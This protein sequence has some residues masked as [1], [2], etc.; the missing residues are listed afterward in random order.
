MRGKLWSEFHKVALCELPAMSD[1]L[2]LLLGIQ[3]E[4][5]LLVQST[6]QKLFEM[7]LTNHFSTNSTSV[8]PCT[9]KVSLSKDKLNALQYVVDLFL[10]LC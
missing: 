2:F 7:V 9:E 8:T 4:D 3:C 1:E 5:Q 10:M 6:N